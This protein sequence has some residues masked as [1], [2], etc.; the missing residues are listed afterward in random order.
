MVAEG[1]KDKWRTEGEDQSTNPKH[2][3]GRKGDMERKAVFPP[4]LPK[5]GTDRDISK[6]EEGEGIGSN[7]D[8]SNQQRMKRTKAPINYSHDIP[9]VRHTVS[10]SSKNSNNPLLL[11]HPIHA[12][13]LGNLGAALSNS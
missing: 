3:F 13:V 1:S 5:E 6:S 4:R 9:D 11:I 8:K 2:A 7:H 12:L 10:I